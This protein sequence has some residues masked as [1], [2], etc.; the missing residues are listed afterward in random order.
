[1]KRRFR[2]PLPVAFTWHVSREE[3]QATGQVIEIGSDGAIFQ[4]TTRI[5]VGTIATVSVAWPVLL[6]NRCRLQLI[7]SGCVVET[8]GEQFTMRI[9][10]YDFR[11]ARRADADPAVLQKPMYGE[12]APS[13]PHV[14]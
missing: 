11:T 5:P 1:M 14:F 4:S 12:P 7:L 10:R 6:D 3:C 8:E 9:D 2:I 13:R